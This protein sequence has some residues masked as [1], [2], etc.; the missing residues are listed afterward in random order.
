MVQFALFWLFSLN[1]A[2]ILKIQFS[3]EDTC[4]HALYSLVSPWLCPASL[5]ASSFT[6]QGRRWSSRRRRGPSLFFLLLF[7][8]LLPRCRGH[9][10]KISFHSYF[11]PAPFSCSCLFF[12]PGRRAVGYY[13][14]SFSSQG[15]WEL[16]VPSLCPRK[17]CLPPRPLSP[18]SMSLFAGGPLGTVSFSPQPHTL[19]FSPTLLYSSPSQRALP[20]PL[21]SLILRS[22]SLSSGLLKGG[23]VSR[24]SPHRSRRVVGRSVGLTPL[25]DLVVVVVGRP[26]CAPRLRPEEDGEE[27]IRD[28]EGGGGGRDLGRA[29]L[30]IFLLLLSLLVGPVVAGHPR[31]SS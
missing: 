10:S 6:P 2:V 4:V 18:C 16:K 27:R 24:L 14:L 3:A 26:I 11:F 22:F 29:F 13:G 8:F 19:T 21:P 23:E 20:P 30:L 31:Y 12:W 17:R 15:R 9:I 1:F 25:F 7:G 28:W 5:T